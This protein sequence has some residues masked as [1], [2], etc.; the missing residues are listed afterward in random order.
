MTEITL[1]FELDGIHEEI[2]DQFDDE[3]AA[4]LLTQQLQP[5]LEE[6][7]YRAYQNAKYDQ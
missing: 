4:Q 6:G 2:Y 3:R 1:T 7:L 5:S